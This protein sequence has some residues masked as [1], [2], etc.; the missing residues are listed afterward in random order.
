MAKFCIINPNDEKCYTY[1]RAR[2]RRIPLGQAYVAAALVNGGH[3]VTAIDATADDLNEDDIVE[4]VVAIQ[5]DFVGIG[6]TTPLYSQMA[7]LTKKIKNELENVTVILGGPHVSAL[8]IP[9]LNTSMADFICIGEAEESVVAVVNCVSNNSPAGLIPGIAYHGKSEPIVT[10]NYRLRLNQSKEDTIKAVDLNACPIPARHLYDHSKYVDEARGFYESQTGAMFSRGCPGKCSFCGAADTLV[11]WRDTDNII[12]E[13]K[14]VQSMGI[15]NLF[16]MD[17]TYTNNRKRV[18]DLS[19]RIVENGIDLNISVQLRLDQLDREVCDAMYKSGVRYVG[20]GIE[21]GSPRIMKAIGKGPKESR[22]HMREKIK[23]LQEYDWSIRCSYVF[24]MVGET[25]EDI[26]MTIDF[27]KE[28]NATENAFSILTPYPDSP[29]WHTAL[30]RGQV[31]EYMD[32]DRFLY[33]NSVGCNLS[34][35]PTDRLMELHKLAYT[36]VKNR[37][38]ATSDI[39]ENAGLGGTLH[40]EQE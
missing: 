29:L 32:F 17:D 36:E 15:P 28:L 9:S 2:T 37:S 5:P 31:D 11:R 19:N 30:Q 14:Q 20:P 34:D 40:T 18:I 21:S 25:E 38:Y 1:S 10:Q 26:M 4:R 39:L 7:S 16:V 35:T 3:D 13:L 27:A 6:G 24:G 22:E 33:Y 12:E 23:L 8:P